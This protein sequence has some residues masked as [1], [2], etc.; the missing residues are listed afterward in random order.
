M[1][2][3]RLGET[4]FAEEGRSSVFAMLD[5]QRL[6]SQTQYAARSLHQIIVTGKHASFRVVDEQNVQALEH[7]K[8]C[9]AMVFDPVIHRVAGHQF[10]VRHLF[11]DAPLKHRINVGQK[12]IFGVAISLGNLRLEG[13][14]DIQIGDVSLGFIQIFEIR[15]FPEKALARGVLYAPRVDVARLEYGLLLGAKVLAH[16]SDHTHIGKETGGQ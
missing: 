15:T 4:M 13:C 5:D 3:L 9:R 8:Q 10:Y 12:Q 11:A 16:D 1:R 2:T 14:K 7:F 6:R